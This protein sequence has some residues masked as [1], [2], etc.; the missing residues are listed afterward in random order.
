[1]PV[2]I[3]S[4]PGEPSRLK[5]RM[6]TGRWRNS[7]ARYTVMPS[8]PGPAATYNCVLGF[9]QGYFG[10]QRRA[11]GTN[12]DDRWFIY[13]LWDSGYVK[14]AAKKEGADSEELKNSIVR[15]LAKGDICD[16]PF[17]D[18]LLASRQVDAIVNF[19]AESH[20]DR[21]ILDSGP[22]IQTNIIGTQT[23][24]D[25]ARQAKLGRYLQVST[26]EVYGSLGPTGLFTEE[27]PIAPNSPYSASK[28]SASRPFSYIRHSATEAATP[29]DA[30]KGRPTTSSFF[31]LP[32]ALAARMKPMSA[33]PSSTRS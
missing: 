11:L 31:I 22:F 4:P 27:T 6:R 26:D 10:F 32:A 2:A 8:A 15:M 21:S 25:A 5:C 29:V 20:V 16:R 18:G 33:T 1:M 3:I 23:L 17:I 24:L 19:A 13:S 9:G 28:A 12:P 14:N 30:S 7:V